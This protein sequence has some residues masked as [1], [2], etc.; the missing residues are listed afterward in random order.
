MYI[1]ILSTAYIALVL[2]V[3]LPRI[4][5]RNSICSIYVHVNNY[6]YDP[7]ARHVLDAFATE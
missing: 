1:C 4:K 5:T 7:A 2:Q 3:P 6:F